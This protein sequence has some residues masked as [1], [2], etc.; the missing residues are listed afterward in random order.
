M[1]ALSSN[2]ARVRRPWYL[3][4]TPV[5]LLVTSY[6]IL[7]EEPNAQGVLGVCVMAGRNSI[8]PATLLYPKQGSVNKPAT[9]SQ[10]RAEFSTTI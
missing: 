5:L 1:L 6:F 10:S 8:I 4:F 3:A 9:L 7:G 2:S